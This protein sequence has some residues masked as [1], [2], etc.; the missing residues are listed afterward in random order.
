PEVD[1]ELAAIPGFGGRVDA[2]RHVP[3]LG[4]GL[5]QA[6]QE[7]RLGGP[8]D[9][10]QRTDSSGNGS[11][12]MPLKR[13]GHSLGWDGGDRRQME[14]ATTARQPSG[15]RESNSL[16]RKTKVRYHDPQL[17]HAAAGT[18]PNSSSRLARYR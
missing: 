18:Q 5:D 7:A 9:K 4:D 14:R 11:S 10:K 1:A 8:G 2:G 16:N 12:P 6:R 3:E 15:G 13:P 17:I